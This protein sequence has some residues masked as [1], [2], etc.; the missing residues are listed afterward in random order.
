MGKW[1]AA[2]F[3]APLALATGAEAQVKGPFAA[4]EAVRVAT[5]R[6][7]DLRLHE[8]RGYPGAPPLVSGMIVQR[9]LAPNAVIGLGMANI[10]AKRKGSDLRLGERPARAKKPAVSFVLRF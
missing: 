2:A 4:A 5:T 1:L 6:V 9:E 3:A 7:L 8:E 10:Y